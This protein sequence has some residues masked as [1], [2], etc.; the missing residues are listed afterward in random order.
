[1]KQVIIRIRDDRGKL[2][3]KIYYTSQAQYFNSSYSAFK[4]IS[5]QLLPGMEVQIKVGNN[6]S[7]FFT[8][9]ECEDEVVLYPEEFKNVDEVIY[10]ESVEDYSVNYFIRNYL[11]EY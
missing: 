6:Y 4:F 2:I 7:K 1:M 10:H 3:S 5:E 8:Y 9:A 11:P